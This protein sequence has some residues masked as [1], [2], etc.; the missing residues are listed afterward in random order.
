M[1]L[2]S[3]SN[4]ESEN[5]KEKEEES[6]MWY[7]AGMLVVS[8]DC[9]RRLYVLHNNFMVNFRLSTQVKPHLHNNSQWLV[10]SNIRMMTQ[11][12]TMIAHSTFLQI[13]YHNASYHYYYHT[14]RHITL[15][16]L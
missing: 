12:D 10:P 13:L 15:V 14:R 2:A 4:K 9:E 7:G 16:G 11:N 8:S 3:H 6:F 5:G 1:H